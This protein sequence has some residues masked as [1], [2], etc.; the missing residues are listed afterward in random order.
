MTRNWVIADNARVKTESLAGAA[1]VHFHAKSLKSLA[2]LQKVASL[3]VP[4]EVH[5][6]DRKPA[7]LVH[8]FFLKNVTRITVHAEALRAT[9]AL[10]KIRDAGFE[11]G[12]AFRPPANPMVMRLYA[13]L[14][15]CVLVVLD[16]AGFDGRAAE[17]V[18][19]LREVFGKKVA[20]ECAS[21]GDLNSAKAAGADEIACKPALFVKAAHESDSQ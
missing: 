11:A 13:D 12:L 2:A 16:E 14:A 3:G 18:R 15:D 6:L 20:V 21:I 8:H 9:A 10:Q 17:K 7:E 4:V 19:V 1:G 5:V